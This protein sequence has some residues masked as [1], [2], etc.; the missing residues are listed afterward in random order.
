MIKEGEKVDTIYLDLPFNSN[1]V[2]NLIFR[3]G[4][5]GGG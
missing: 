5:G 2:Y 3:W 1:R 4:G